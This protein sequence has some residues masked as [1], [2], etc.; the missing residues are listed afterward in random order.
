MIP[1]HYKTEMV[2]AAGLAT[3]IITIK[4]RG[5]VLSYTP[6]MVGEAS[7]AIAAPRSQGEC[8]ASELLPNMRW[9]A[10]PELHRRPSPSEGAALSAALRAEMDLTTGF[11][12]APTAFV[13]QGSV[14]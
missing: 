3:S 14:C 10:R 11:A 1:F 12:P 5:L 8:S 6:K 4:S 13:A 2:G 9:S 7:F